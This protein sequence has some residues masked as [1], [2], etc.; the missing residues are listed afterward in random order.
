MKIACEKGNTQNPTGYKRYL[1]LFPQ[2]TPVNVEP[3]SK[4]GQQNKTDR[5]VS[6]VKI[7][8]FILLF[9]W[10]GRAIELSS[11]AFD[12]QSRS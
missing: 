6:E 12:Y 3:V 5:Q 1:F 2:I 9:S 8:I 11:Y 7:P 4:T 10:K